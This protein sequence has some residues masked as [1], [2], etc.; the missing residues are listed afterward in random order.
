MIM[1]RISESRMMSSDITRLNVQV[2]HL[3]RLWLKNIIT[4]GYWS[5]DPELVSDENTNIKRRIK[6]RQIIT[7]V[8]LSR[9]WGI[10]VC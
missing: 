5:R 10:Y 8:V 7:N 6:S 2:T 9:R 3:W 1:S 4:I